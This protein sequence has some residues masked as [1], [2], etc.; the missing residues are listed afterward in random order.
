MALNTYAGL[1]EALLSWLDIEIG[2]AGVDAGRV[3]DAIIL[4]EAK[5]RRN[6]RVRETRAQ[7]SGLTRV[8]EEIT[9]I[10]VP[11]GY[12]GF[13]DLEITFG[14]RPLK[15]R[16][17]GCWAE[18]RGQVLAIY[19]L[20]L[21]D[22]P[23]TLYYWTDLVALNPTPDSTNWILQRHPDAYLYGAK[24]E[25]FD[26]LADPREVSEREKF[27]GVMQQI[28]DNSIG[29]EWFSLPQVA[30]GGGSP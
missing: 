24:A 13:L 15:I 7:V 28:N 26:F 14:D 5:I 3:Y 19:P 21:P 25:L 30:T 12:Q 2:Q 17:V 16:E 22:R 10:D 1:E 23:Y 4:A 6:L 9:L 8:E 27:N 11:A 18:P 20:L 29:R